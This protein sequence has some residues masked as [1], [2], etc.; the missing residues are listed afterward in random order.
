M[1]GKLIARRKRATDKAVVLPTVPEPTFSW[2]LTP[3]STM[4][5][6]IGFNAASDTL[7]VVFR[8]SGRQCQYDGFSAI[9][10]FNFKRAKSR[11]R[12]WRQYILPLGGT[13]VEREKM[14]HEIKTI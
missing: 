10:F 9:R 13:E 2:M 4:F 6:A 5:F 11:G 8:K 7:R 14:D 3:D 1:S 12:Y